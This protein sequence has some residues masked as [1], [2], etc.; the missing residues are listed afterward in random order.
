M[1][2]VARAPFHIGG[3]SVA[4]GER[5]NV[6]LPLS[7]MS[8]R[9]PINL[10][11]H[12]IHGRRDGPTVFVCAAIHGDEVVGVE[13]ERR[14][15]CSRALHGL[16]GTALLVPIV[17]AFGFI[18]HS[19][20]LPDRR[21][22]N[23][24]FPGSPTGSLAAQLAHLFTTEIVERCDHGI[25]LHTAAINRANL[26][27][28]RV[29]AN[30]EGARALAEAFDAPIILHAALRVGSLRETAAARDVPVIVYECGEAL[31]FDELSL[32][33]GTRGVVR[34]LASLGMIKSR[35]RDASSP[36]RESAIS[37]QS[38]WLRAPE[39]GIFRARRTI[40]HHVQAGDV[41]GV[42]S[43]PFGETRSE[44]RAPDTGLIVGRNNVPAVNQG[45]ALFHVAV[46]A[47]PA[48]L[49][50]SYGRLERGLAD[51][52]LDEDEDA[53]V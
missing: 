52:L 25:D 41:L 18:G 8:N 24:C 6:D 47:D 28:V 14:L 31:R 27:Q 17:N 26:P 16:A 10:P 13:N 39:G 34:V 51:P 2:Q 50:R 22:L 49:Q 9:A 1:R 19:R 45:D 42:V 35:G 37:T 40:G 23:R 7:L 38:R 15:L 44:I 33:I 32:R 46:I 12:V 4:P 30:H 11:V 48:E 29:D 21:D 20:Y 5:R 3:I 43:D 53:I 36:K